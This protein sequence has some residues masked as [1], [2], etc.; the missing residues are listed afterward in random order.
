VCPSSSCI[1][2]FLK[3]KKVEATMGDLSGAIFGFVSYASLQMCEGVVVGYT[4]RRVYVENDVPLLKTR[5][6]IRFSS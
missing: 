5:V 4:K 2:P 3:K 1:E 6:C